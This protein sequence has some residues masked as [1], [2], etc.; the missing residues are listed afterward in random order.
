MSE[1]VRE[2][3]DVTKYE[4]RTEEDSSVLEDEVAERKTASIETE[5]DEIDGM[6][7]RASKIEQGRVVK[8]SNGLAV[9]QTYTVKRLIARFDNNRNIPPSNIARK[10][11]QTFL[12]S[13]ST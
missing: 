8:L 2:E 11:F 5:N 7:L 4:E 1:T 6:M 9:E 12:R 10:I 3:I 13:V